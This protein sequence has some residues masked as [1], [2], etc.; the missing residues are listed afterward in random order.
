MSAD[1]SMNDSENEEE[2]VAEE[3]SDSDSGDE[4]IKL[5]QN[6]ISVL[7]KLSSDTKTYDDYVLLVS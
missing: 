2:I 5:N 4:E 6:F 1:G 3:E 7:Q